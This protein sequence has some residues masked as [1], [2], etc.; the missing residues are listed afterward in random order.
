MKI[1]VTNRYIISL[2][3]CLALF[4]LRVILFT[5]RVQY[6]NKK[7]IDEFLV[8]EKKVVITTWH[9]C[10]IYFFTLWFSSLQARMGIC[11]L[12]LPKK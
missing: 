3:S 12:I 5:C 6:I 2:L 4:V 1:R 11:C 9:R 8:G 10:A 7:H